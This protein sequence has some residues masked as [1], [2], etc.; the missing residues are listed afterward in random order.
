[1]NE[2]QFAA[3]LRANKLGASISGGFTASL[4]MNGSNMAQATQLATTAAAAVSFGAIHGAP[5]KLMIVNLDP[6]TWYSVSGVP[7]I[8]AGGTGYQAGDVLMIVGGSGIAATVTV[9]TISGGGGSGPIASIALTTA[10]KYT[11]SPSSPNTPTGGHGT[12]A[13]LTFTMATN[14]GN[15]LII[16]GDNLM[17]TF[18]QSL[19]PQDFILLSPKSATIYAMAAAGT[20]E[21]FV[22]AT[23]A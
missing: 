3:Q 2:V 4:N 13:S 22:V 1:M 14:A 6:A 17:A 23:E 15:L 16:A 21:F 18:P 12:G 5:S 11:Q 10:G 7:T 8:A 9:S 19:P 20:V